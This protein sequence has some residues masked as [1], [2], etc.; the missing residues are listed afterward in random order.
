M[1]LL[2]DG[3]MRSRPGEDI[4]MLLGRWCMSCEG[5]SGDRKT[6]VD[7]YSVSARASRFIGKKISGSY[8]SSQKSDIRQ[9]SGAFEN[10]NLHGTPFAHFDIWWHPIIGDAEKMGWYHQSHDISPT[11][12]WTEFSRIYILWAVIGYDVILATVNL[13]SDGLVPP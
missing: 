7:A 2:D 1:E 12:Q 5:D 11:G 6:S 8:L 9:P 4:C 10:K 13:D 3:G